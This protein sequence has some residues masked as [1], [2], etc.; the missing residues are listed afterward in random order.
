MCGRKRLQALSRLLCAPRT[1]DTAGSTCVCAVARP[2]CPL[3]LAK[4]LLLSFLD[5]DLLL[6]FRSSG[7]ASNSVPLFILTLP[8]GAH[9][10]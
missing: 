9:L 5:L 2:P 4:P 7:S 8:L 3:P 1:L 10:V 6:T